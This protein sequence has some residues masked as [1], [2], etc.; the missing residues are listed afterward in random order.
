MLQ[1]TIKGNLLKIDLLPYTLKIIFKIIY[2]KVLMEIHALVIMDTY[3]KC[4]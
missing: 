3:T 4:E 1:K 2:V